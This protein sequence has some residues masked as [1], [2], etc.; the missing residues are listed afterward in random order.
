MWVII[1]RKSVLSFKAE[2]F[3][4]IP[5]WQLCFTLYVLVKKKGILQP[6]LILSLMS[7]NILYI[8]TVYKTMF[9][10]VGDVYTQDS[11]P[12]GSLSRQYLLDRSLILSPSL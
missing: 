1:E 12:S 10:R 11:N 5:K 6:E 9:K 7:R 4:R 8:C 3:K 2:L